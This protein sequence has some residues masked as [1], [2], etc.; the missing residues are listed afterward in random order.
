M[1]RVLA[2]DGV[3]YDT[4]EHIS[5]FLHSKGQSIRPVRYLFPANVVVYY[6]I[7]SPKL[8]SNCTA[9]SGPGRK[10]KPKRFGVPKVI[11]LIF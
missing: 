6:L 7:R 9:R 4:P 1:C 10:R 3:I 2:D 11:W 8:L 5:E